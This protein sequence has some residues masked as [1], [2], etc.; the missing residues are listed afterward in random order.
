MT[1]RIRFES[2]PTIYYY[3]AMALP[4]DVNWMR[5]AS[6]RIRFQRRINL[7]EKLF[8]KIW[9]KKLY[10]EKYPLQLNEELIIE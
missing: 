4:S 5:E 10:Y 2:H 1:R 3:E 9:C 8:M 7:L 6:D